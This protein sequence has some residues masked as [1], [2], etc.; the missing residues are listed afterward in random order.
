[1]I[2]PGNQLRTLGLRG[3]CLLGLAAGSEHAEGR[4]LAGV[5]LLCQALHLLWL[6]LLWGPPYT[7]ASPTVAP[8]VMAP[9]PRTPTIYALP[10]PMAPLAYHGLRRCGTSTATSPSSM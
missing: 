10:L 5:A 8:L 1:M 3:T 7:M 2:A 6:H 9:P 4:T